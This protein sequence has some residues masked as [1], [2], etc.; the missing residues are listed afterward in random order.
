MKKKFDYDTIPADYQFV[1]MTEGGR[2]QKFWH[3]AKLSL[4]ET[5]LLSNNVCS[6]LDLGCGSG[7]VAFYLLRNG[8]FKVCGVDVTKSYIKF[9]N[10][11]KKKENVDGEFKTYDGKKISYEDESFNAIVSSEVIEHVDNPK[12]HLKEIHRVLEDDGLLFL[13]TPNYRKISFWP[14]LEYISDKLSL[15]PKMKGEQHINFYKPNTLKQLLEDSGYEVQEMSSYYGFSPFW[16]IL[17][18]RAA[19]KCFQF[20]F[21]RNN[22]RRMVLYVIARKK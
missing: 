18:R 1:A 2:F 20:E 3:A 16:A 10:E 4:I 12:K 22:T 7:N 19:I 17:S 6:V 15:T 11:R 21:L 9:C 13:T 14:I 8:Q 5:K